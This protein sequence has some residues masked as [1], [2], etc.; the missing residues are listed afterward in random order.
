MR[1]KLS[2]ASSGNRSG[3][4]R[5]LL[6]QDVVVVTRWALAALRR[7]AKRDAGARRRLLLLGVISGFVFWTWLVLAALAVSA[8]LVVAYERWVRDEKIIRLA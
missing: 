7:Q 5:P 2:I 6:V 8:I 4:S 1:A 3:P